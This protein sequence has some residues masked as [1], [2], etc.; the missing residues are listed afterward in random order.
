MF[1]H[2]HRLLFFSHHLLQKALRSATQLILTLVSVSKVNGHN[3]I[4]TQDMVRPLR[5]WAC[6]GF[7]WMLLENSKSCDWAVIL[8]ALGRAKKGPH[9]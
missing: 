4:S 5:P 2:Q 6:Q 1:A 8:E 7:G 9:I 3:L